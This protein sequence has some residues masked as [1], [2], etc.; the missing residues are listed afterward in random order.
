MTATT[1]EDVQVSLG[2]IGT[3]D[4]TP[5]TTGNGK[6]LLNSTGI[7]IKKT[8]GNAHD[9]QVSAPENDWDWSNI[10]DISAYYQIGKLIPASSTTG[11]EIYF[12]PDANGVGKTISSGARF[13]RAD[14][15]VNGST[16]VAD[17]GTTNSYKATLHA[18][19]DGEKDDSTGTGEWSTGSGAVTSTGWDKTND[20]G[21]YVDIPVWLRTSSTE[22]ADIGVIAYVVPNDD[23]IRTNSDGE[24]LYRAVR[25]ALLSEGQAQGGT[26]FSGTGLVAVNDG[27]TGMTSGAYGQIKTNPFG[28]DDAASILNWYNHSG[29]VARGESTGD[30]V[31]AKKSA[32]SNATTRFDSNVYGAPTIYGNTQF[33]KLEARSTQPYGDPTKV[34]V[35]VWLEGED[36]DC[37]NDTAGQNWS[38]NLKF[39][40]TSN[41]PTGTDLSPNAANP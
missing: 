11:E 32:A 41:S 4:N 16:G 20:D 5:E 15:S 2:L 19:V 12:T 26:D 31:A 35:R 37:W 36:P 6:S 7:L 13:I 9:G 18:F 17:S 8:S 22:G 29:A 1:P 21:Y 23:N 14:S 30:D 40:N 3:A 24:A 25:V 34:I 38:I 27:W 10:A 28:T 39:Y 33:V